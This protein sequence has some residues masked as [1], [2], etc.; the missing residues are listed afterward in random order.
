MVV[1]R[2]SVMFLCCCCTLVVTCDQAPDICDINAQCVW[3]TDTDR[4]ECRCIDTAAVVSS[5]GDGDDVSSTPSCDSP[6]DG[7]WGCGL[8]SL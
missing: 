3:S 4:Y 6:V 8:F 5:S 7:M 2:T 1:L